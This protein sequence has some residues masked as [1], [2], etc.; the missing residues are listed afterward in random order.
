MT[1]EAH[2]AYAQLKDLV[3]NSDDVTDLIYA[4]VD[5]DFETIENI[6]AREIVRLLLDDIVADAD[7]MEGFKHA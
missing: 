4:R 2:A 6:D 5:A 3:Y 7:F 1:N